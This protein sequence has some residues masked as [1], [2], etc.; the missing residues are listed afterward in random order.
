MA[1]LPEATAPDG[2]RAPV[3]P[4]GG[5]SWL[6][7]ALTWT[8]PASKAPAARTT[9]ITKS[10]GSAFTREAPKA[11]ISETA[12]NTQMEEARR[13]LIA[14]KVAPDLRGIDPNAEL[15][16][17]VQF[18]DL[19]GEAT[20]ASVRAD[21]G[22]EKRTFAFIRAAVY[23]VRGGSIESLAF[24]PRV[25]YVTPNRDLKP[26]ASSDEM[27][28]V[29][30]PLAWQSGWDGSGIGIA[31]IDSGIR[32]H[33]DLND[34]AT[35][36]SRVVYNETLRP[37]ETASNDGYGHGTHVAGIIAGNGASTT[38]ADRRG[39]AP[40]ANLINL[41][42]LGADGSGT[43]TEAIL[44]IDRAIALKDQ[45]NIRVINLSLGRQVFESHTLDP[46]CQAARRAWEAGIVVVAAAGNQGRNNSQGTK[47]YGTIGSPGNSPYVI[48]VGA[49]RTRG[50]ASRVDDRKA[51]FSSKGPTAIDH[52]VKPDLVAPG[53]GVV[54]L[55]A[56]GSALYNAR[57]AR[58]I[59]SFYFKMSGTS[60]ATPVVSGAV[61]LLLQKEPNLTPDQVKA[62]LMKTAYKV[63]PT[64]SSWTDSATG[65]TYT[66]QY[67]IFT[68]GAG[69]LDISAA[70]SSNE[71]ATGASLS[72]SVTRDA[73]TGQIRLVHANGVIWGSGVIWG[74]GVVWGTG[75]I[76]G[77]SVIWG[78]NAEVNG[79][80][81]IWGT[82]VVW[83]TGSSE[84]F[85]V[86]WGTG[87]I[88]G[89]SADAQSTAL[90]SE[91]TDEDG[92]DSP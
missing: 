51:S 37:G 50:T 18:N 74:T 40:K 15:D 16:V 26:T 4:T 69:Y 9:T 34:P 84:G 48:T 78:T 66:K 54:S 12:A 92:L 65:I 11:P 46:L 13:E 81:V 64:T 10:A 76:W 62:R 39:V 36:D 73:L 27:E 55:S 61:A 1:A 30:A 28:A 59:G 35:G 88:W 42:V 90:S 68:V 70:L 60:M 31:V 32:P 33:S 85:G 41:A 47:G 67:D 52:V 23:R 5:Q 89:T 77:D 56:P 49:M 21:A 7:S 58:R 63:F 24:N 2:A 80:A 8:A 14:A 29:Q 86:V 17:I 57:P 19:P 71:V 72:P 91:L 20:L 38:Q 44:A 53:D 82:G 25:A 75:V 83:G 87:V 79:T 45:Y 43:D 3:A 22:Q 6:R